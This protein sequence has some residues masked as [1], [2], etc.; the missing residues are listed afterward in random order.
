MDLKTKQTYKHA[1]RREVIHKKGSYKKVFKK[2]KF[3]VSKRTY[4]NTVHTHITRMSLI[5]KLHISCLT[6]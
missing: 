3:N 2:Q 5:F 1:L 4:L 6:K